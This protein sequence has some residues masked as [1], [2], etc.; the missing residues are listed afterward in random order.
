M[1]QA[2][3]MYNTVAE[4]DQSVECSRY[5]VDRVRRET[6]ANAEDAREFS[7]M[8][9]HIEPIRR[10]AAMRDPDETS[11][12]MFWAMSEEDNTH[13][14]MYCRH[15]RARENRTKREDALEAEH[16]NLWVCLKNDR[17]PIANVSFYIEKMS[18]LKMAVVDNNS[19]RLIE[20][21]DSGCE[22]SEIDLQGNTALHSA[23]SRKRLTCAKILLNRGADPTIQNHDG[24]VPQELVR[25]YPELYQLLSFCR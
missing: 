25:S 6:I 20:Y 8:L 2:A 9:N 23:A 24:K 18:P 17:E 12:Y 22:I 13:N 21:L 1:C 15:Q 14:E 7:A 3:I 16:M 5:K 10:A 11:F 4:Y 19:D